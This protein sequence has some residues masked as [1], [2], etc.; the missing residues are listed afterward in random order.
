MDRKKDGA[1]LKSRRPVPLQDIETDTAQ[2]VDIRVVDLGE[3]A[4]LGRGHGV[5]VWE[6]E[7]EVEDATWEGLMDVLGPPGGGGRED[8][9]HKATEMGHGS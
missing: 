9:L 8:N 2:L 6:E 3:K 7:L 4:N 5:V 1:D